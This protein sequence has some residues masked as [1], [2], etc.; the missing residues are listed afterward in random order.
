MWKLWIYNNIWGVIRMV[1]MLKKIEVVKKPLNK[2]DETKINELLKT[3]K[4]EQ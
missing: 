4:L 2:D 3:Y 1:K